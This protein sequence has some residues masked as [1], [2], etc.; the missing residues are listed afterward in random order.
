[1]PNPPR[2]RPARETVRAK[3]LEAAEVEFIRSGYAST[4]LDDVVERSGFTKGALYS[5]FESKSAL[6]LALI[7]ERFSRVL[8]NQMRTVLSSVST[9]SASSLDARSLARGLAQ[10]SEQDEAWHLLIVELALLATQDEASA[11]LYRRSRDI[12][13][14][15]IKGALA[16][17]LGAEEESD[18]LHRSEVITTLVIS[19]VNA[20]ALD[21]SLD[22]GRYTLDLRTAL[23][24]S[25]LRGGLAWGL[26]ASPE[27]AAKPE[28]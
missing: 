10:L 16:I 3:V 2:K 15:Q 12:V 22:R 8:S 6:L 7:E 25:A 28:L 20:V 26:K 18:E 11:D 23:F 4:K 27:R 24:E 5:N 14:A 21:G 1:M 13:R 9:G 19:L 17:L